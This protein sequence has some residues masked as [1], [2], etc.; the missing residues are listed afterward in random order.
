[1]C[2]CASLFCKCSLNDHSN[3]HSFTPQTRPTTNQVK[4][5]DDKSTYTGVYVH[6]GPS[7]NDLFQHITD[8]ALA[9]RG[10]DYDVR[11]REATL[12]QRE[13]RPF[14]DGWDLSLIHI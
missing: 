11:A 2:F 9:P 14:N 1:M 7:T 13:A 4:F 5:H 6:G 3:V 10:L 8:A 12:R